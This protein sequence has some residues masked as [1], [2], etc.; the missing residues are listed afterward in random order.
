MDRNG[1]IRTLHILNLAIWSMGQGK[2]RI[3]FYLPLKTL[4]DNG[5]EVWF[6]TSKKTQENGKVES[7]NLHNVRNIINPSQ[8]TSLLRQYCFSI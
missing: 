8:K 7:V 4:C 1:S 5:H 2:G 6:L 3:S